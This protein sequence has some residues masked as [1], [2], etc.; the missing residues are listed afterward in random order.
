[1][2]TEI[3]RIVRMTFKPENLPLFLKIFHDSKEQIRAMKG[4]RHLELWQD[5]HAPHV[6]STFSIWESEE[7]LNAYRNSELFGKVWPNTKALFAEK[8]NAFSVV[9]KVTL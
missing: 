7:H 2:S 5:L 9:Q 4:C 8:P 3:R 6:C 1:M